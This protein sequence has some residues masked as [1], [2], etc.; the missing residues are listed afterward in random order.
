MKRKA[1]GYAVGGVRGGSRGRPARRFGP[2]GSERIARATRGPSAGARRLR[3]PITEFL[4][5]AQ[6]GRRP[7][8]SSFVA[9]GRVAFVARSAAARSR[10]HSGRRAYPR[11]RSDSRTA[12][13]GEF[14][15]GGTSVKE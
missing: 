5:Q 12:P 1:C 2:P 10:V 11:A 4:N 6:A 13:G 8:A 3:H 15:W 9:R 7:G 14:D